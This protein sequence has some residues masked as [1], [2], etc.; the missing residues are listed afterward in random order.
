MV[1]SPHHWGIP[2]RAEDLYAPTFRALTGRS[3][4]TAVRIDEVEHG[5]AVRTR[6]TIIG[7]PDLPQHAFIKLAPVRPG[8]L[9]LN[10]YMDLANTEA[11][12]YRSI[13]AE[14]ADCIPKV[15]GAQSDP[16]SSRAVVI[17]EDLTE[18]DARFL[19]VAKGCSAT[20]ALAIA[21]A[22]GDLHRRFW[23]SD[24]LITGDLDGLSPTLSRSTTRGPRAWPLLWLIPRRYHD[25]VPASLRAETSMLV[26]RRWSIAASLGTYPHTLIHGATHAGTIC[27]VSGR[28][29]FFDWQVASCGPAV[30]DLSYFA[31]TSLDT[32]T[33]RKID[34][35]L[36]ETY[37]AHLN[38]DGIERLSFA[39]AWDAYRLLAFTAYVAAGVTSVFGRQLQSEESTRA[40]LDR[41]AQAMCDLDSLERLRNRL[42]HR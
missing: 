29:L 24:R 13:S 42:D 7:E 19:P 37:V 38:A 16:R 25:V 11:L 2:R 15:Y 5:T 14:L 22:L 40:G 12:I 3:D 41:A 34:R 18:R 20:D 26:T 27:F 6:V 36:V 28:P 17:M 8:E 39:E 1:N 32:E 35:Q 23:R 9:L 4:V 31:C 33:R 21:A 10:R 30:K